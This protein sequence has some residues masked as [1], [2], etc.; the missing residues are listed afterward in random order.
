MYNGISE[1]IINNTEEFKLGYLRGVEDS[2]RK[3][4]IVKEIVVTKDNQTD[5]QKRLLNSL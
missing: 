2:Q 1:E 4:D 3:K 5:F